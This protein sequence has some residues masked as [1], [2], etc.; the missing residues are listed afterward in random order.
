MGR[1]FESWCDLHAEAVLEKM[2][3]ERKQEREAWHIERESW[4]NKISEREQAELEECE[5]AWAI[6]H[7][8][9]VSRTVAAAE[10]A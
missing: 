7:V 1:G 6:F 2:E 9:A 3:K 5:A 8:R 10:F 4:E